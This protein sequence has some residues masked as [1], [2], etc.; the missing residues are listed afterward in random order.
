MERERL[1]SSEEEKDTL[2][3][4]TKKFKESQHFARVN[5]KS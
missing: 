3:L 1:K 4:S 5:E 2:R